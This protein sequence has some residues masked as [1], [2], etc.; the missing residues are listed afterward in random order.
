MNNAIIKLRYNLLS[1]LF[2]V[3]FAIVGWKNYAEFKKEVES[4]IKQK[5]SLQYEPFERSTS[6]MTI[7]QTGKAGKK[8]SK[9]NQR[10]SNLESKALA[11][12]K[13]TYKNIGIGFGFLL[14]LSGLLSLLDISLLSFEFSEVVS[15]EPF[16]IVVGLVMMIYYSVFS[17]G[18][19]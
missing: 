1:K 19:D 11:N 16:V 8:F 5:I 17:K 14:F 6:K 2:L 7:V 10:V 13:Q 3:V 4:I 18:Y 15:N 9:Y 12:Q